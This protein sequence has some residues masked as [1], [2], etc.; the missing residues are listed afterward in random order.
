MEDTELVNYLFWP[1]GSWKAEWKT[2]KSFV[3]VLVVTSNYFRRFCDKLQHLLDIPAPSLDACS[4][5][6]SVDYQR[7]I[8]LKFPQVGKRITFLRHLFPHFLSSF[9]H[10]M[11]E[12]GKIYEIYI[13]IYIE[14]YLHNVCS[15]VF[16]WTTERQDEEWWVC[17]SVNITLKGCLPFIFLE[18][19]SLCGWYE[20]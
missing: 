20:S 10:C 9:F 5:A 4:A 8:C 17:V 1:W 14:F 18:I 11:H 6:C 15:G 13:Y 16:N 3:V 19:S 7:Q 12:I 2:N